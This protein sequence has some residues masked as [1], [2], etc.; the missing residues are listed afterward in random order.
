MLSPRLIKL[1]MQIICPTITHIINQSIITSVSPGDL[2][3]VE[4]SPLFKKSDTMSKKKKS[5]RLS[6]SDNGEEVK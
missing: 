4:L 3:E 1:S 2:K 6:P 5:E